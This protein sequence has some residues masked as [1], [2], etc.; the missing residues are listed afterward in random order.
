MQD[1]QMPIKTEI[2]VEKLKRNEISVNELIKSIKLPSLSDC[3]NDMIGKK[4]V[5]IEAL[6]GLASMSRA[7]FYRV[8]NGETKPSRNLLLR[9]S[10]VLGNTYEETQL[11]LK[12]GNC[13]ALSGTRPRDVI[14]INGILHHLDIEQISQN[15]EEN[16]FVNLYSRG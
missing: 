16:G 13:A 2:I 1:K 9:I 4:N 8:I 6:T 10:L 3:L 5:T 12:C 7:S 15:L 14:L 11:L